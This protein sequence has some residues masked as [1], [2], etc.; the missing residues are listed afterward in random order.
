MDISFTEEQEML[1]NSARDF[2]TTEC[3]KTLTRELE[4]DVLLLVDP[5][6]ARFP[7]AVRFEFPSNGAW[8]QT[9]EVE[10]PCCICTAGQDL[11]RGTTDKHWNLIIAAKKTLNPCHGGRSSLRP[12]G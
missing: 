9:D 10:V 7:E 11:D 4:E 3:S 5:V 12:I 8:H 2:L 6:T 1:R